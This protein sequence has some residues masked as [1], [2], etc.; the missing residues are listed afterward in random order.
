MPL[1][2][3]DYGTGS[4]I[5]DDTDITT[6]ILYFSTAEL[7]EFK[8]LCKTGMKIE[9]GKDYKEKGNLS[10]LLLIVL[11]E[12][13]ENPDASFSTQLNALQNKYGSR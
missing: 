6:T 12:K 8:T 3:H 7:K 1:F 5:K 13:F 11:R 2:E 10:D 4:Q 9:F